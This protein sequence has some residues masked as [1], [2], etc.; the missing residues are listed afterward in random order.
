M[1]AACFQVLHNTTDAEDA[2]MDAFK[3]MSQNASRFL[4][5]QKKETLAMAYRY[6][7]NAALD[8]YRKN[9][10]RNNLYV[11]IEDETV[12]ESIPDLSERFYDIS[13]TE[14]H[15][16]MLFEALMELKKELRDPIVMKYYHHMKNI[17]IAKAMG[18]DINTLNGRIYRAKRLLQKRM[19]EKGYQ[20]E[21]SK[22][23]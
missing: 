9:Q 15:K 12:V 2:A 16:Q 10:R 4:D 8:F 6:A 18:L 13:I 21:K 19:L 14:Q 5:Y 17:E 3:N 1:V 11:S 22:I 23:Q 20:G 7:H